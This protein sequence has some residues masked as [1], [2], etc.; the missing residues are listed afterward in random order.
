[1]K[2]T[3]IKK[4][5]AALLVLAI[6]LSFAGCAKINYVTD[7]AIQAIKEV[8]DGS[9]ETGG[10]LGAAT[11]AA[12]AEGEEGSAGTES[13]QIDDLVPGTYGGVD[14]Q[15]VEDIVN[16]YAKAY[17][18]TKTKS[19]QYNTPDGTETWYAMVGEED[20][21]VHDILVE[22][23]SN[24]IINSLVPGIMSSVYK[25]SAQALSPGSSRKFDE[26]T[27][28]TCT[29]TA[30]DVLAANVKDNGDGTITLQIQPKAASMSAK[31]EDAQG[32]LFN[33]LGDIGSAVESVGVS[34]ASGSTEENCV[35]NYQNGYAT[36][37]IDT[38][39]GEITSAVYLMKVTVDVQHATIAVITDKSASL[40]ID[41]TLTFPASDEWLKE[42]MD[43]TR[44]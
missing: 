6:V 40:Q 16:Y 4:L 41:Y 31:G 43:T 37:T 25:P 35:V 27:F 36:V 5:T 12:G 1:M 9:W 7:G 20:L 38:A 17:D 13:K 32:R 18:L 3:S 15:T 2:K 33:S 26:D 10:A 30:D 14:F 19:A 24:S 8:Q 44:A 34:W 22:G 11:G 39:S 42:Y 23:K 28:K 21:Q 29:L